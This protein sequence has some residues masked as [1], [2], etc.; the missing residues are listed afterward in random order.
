MDSR[1][2]AS[3]LR[4]VFPVALLLAAAGFSLSPGR[5][6]AESANSDFKQGQNAEAREDY[7]AAFDDYQKA[8]NPESQRSALQ[9]CAR[10]RS[11]HGILRFTSPGAASWRRPAVTHRAR[12]PSSST[13][14]K[15]T[16]AMRPRNRKLPGSA[17]SRVKARRA[18][19]GHFPKPPAEASNS[20][21]SSRPPVE[22]KPVSNEPLTLHIHRGLPRSFTRP[23]ARPPASMSLRSRLQLQAHPG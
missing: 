5:I 4:F 18:R 1:T 14:R 15:S 11:R 3:G 13:P 10:P 7:D 20:R 6:H 16:P 23:S 2:P 8:L 9:D 21:P 22:L 12:L 19:S 17:R